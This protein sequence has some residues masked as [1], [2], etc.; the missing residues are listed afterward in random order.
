MKGELEA[1]SEAARQRLQELLQ[2]RRICTKSE[3]FVP[4]Y[5]TVLLAKWMKP[6]KGL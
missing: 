3:A 6:L 1:D 5:L 2:E 4:G